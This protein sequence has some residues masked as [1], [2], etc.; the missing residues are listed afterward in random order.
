MDLIEEL[1]RKVYIG[2]Y[3]TLTFYREGI[4]VVT[5]KIMGDR[6]ILLITNNMKDL[7]VH[8]VY[9]NGNIYDLAN[10]VYNLLIE[11]EISVEGV[12]SI[13][14]SDGLFIHGRVQKDR[15]IIVQPEVYADEGGEDIVK[16]IEYDISI[17]NALSELTIAEIISVFVYQYFS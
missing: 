9:Y 13:G 2:Q 5:V 10:E 8:T 7:N 11:D 4:P 15:V 16:D 17:R 14:F 3:N 12:V 6:D 1:S